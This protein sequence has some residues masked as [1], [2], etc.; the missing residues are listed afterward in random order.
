MNPLD[1][2]MERKEKKEETPLRRVI[3]PPKPPF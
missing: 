3:I 1:S 2:A